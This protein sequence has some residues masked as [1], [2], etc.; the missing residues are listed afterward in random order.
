LK[1]AEYEVI[2]VNASDYPLSKTGWEQSER[3][4]TIETNRHERT[5]ACN[6]GAAVARSDYLIFLDED[7]WPLPV[8]LDSFWQVAS[9]KPKAGWLPGVY[10]QRYSC[11]AEFCLEENCFA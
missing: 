9:Q 11:K 2:V 4:D 1:Q 7:D 3:A 5:I 8:A 6:S 10:R